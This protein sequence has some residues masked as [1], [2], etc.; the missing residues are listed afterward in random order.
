MGSRVRGPGRP[1]AAAT[2]GEGVAGDGEQGGEAHEFRPGGGAVR[3]DRAV[4]GRGCGCGVA[5][6]GGEGGDAVRVIGAPRC[7]RVVAR[8][9]VVAQARGEAFQL[10][11]LLPREA[12]PSPTGSLK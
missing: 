12:G 8:V 6:G 3:G 1:P 10:R 2:P 5:V 4:G 7:P 11:V 9:C